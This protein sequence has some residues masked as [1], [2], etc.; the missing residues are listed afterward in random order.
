MMRLFNYFRHQTR[1]ILQYFP[2]PL[3]EMV[4]WAKRSVLNMRSRRDVF[5]KVF[6]ANGWDGTESVSGP[7]STME[8]TKPL[9]A[10]LP[11]LLEKYEVRTLLDIPCGDAHWISRTLTKNVEYIGADIVPELIKNNRNSKA[12]LGR[13][14]V[15][16]LVSDKLPEADL[17]MVRDCFIHLPHRM[18]R[19]AIANIERSGARYLLTTTYSGHADNIDIEIGGFRP[20]DL[21]KPPYCLPPP[22]ETIFEAD[23]VNSGKSISL[24]KVSS[25]SGRGKKASGAGGL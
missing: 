22:L 6:H 4:R 25:L 3:A 18:V 1:Q 15:I 24:W 21:Q 23:N 11:H 8:A 2:T 13:F 17:V 12:E 16:D 20:V 5:R 7:G 14:E 10:A 9:R 19:R